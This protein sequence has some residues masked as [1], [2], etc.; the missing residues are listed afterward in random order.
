MGPIMQFQAFGEYWTGF[1]KGYD[2]TDNKTLLAF[3]MWIAALTLN[4]KKNRPIW[5]IA[6]AIFT[7][8][9]FSIP[10]SLFGSELNYET[11][12]VIQGMISLF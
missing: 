10:H 3:V 7:L 11:G 2:L 12:K 5:I 9:I 1:P 8:I 6:A 4:L